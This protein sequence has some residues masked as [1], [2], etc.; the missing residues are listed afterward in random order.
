MSYS[1]LCKPCL[2]SQRSSLA[3]ALLL[4]LLL[5][6]CGNPRKDGNINQII[7]APVKEN[8]EAVRFTPKF[9]V[10]G[11]YRTVR[12]LRVEEFTA[13]ER[14]VTSSIDETL[15]VIEA[16]DE[17]GRPLVV[18]RTWEVSQ[19]TFVK[20]YGRGESSSGQLD[21]VTLRLRQRPEKTEVEV[22]AGDLD[23]R[24]RQLFI[25]GLDT[26]LLPLDP[27]R[28]GD[29]WQLGSSRLRAFE[30]FLGKFDF[31]INSNIVDCAL[32]ELDAS[33]AIIDV[34]WRISGMMAGQTAVLEFKGKL[35]H[36]RE[37]NLN[38]S[39]VLKGGRTG[40]QGDNS[41]IEINIQRKKI[42]NWLDLND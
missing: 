36:S 16:V 25:E 8:T 26:G 6:A 20:G 35:V 28:Q 4:A 27:I 10:N 39:F 3:F 15:T 21:G 19:T 7:T 11:N 18:K 13:T 24:G 33:R 40:E 9:E 2:F 42:S 5:T 31:K 17:S 1:E 37:H 29:H 12:T 14:F 22:L 23:V 38:T 41:I 34:T 30:R 32:V